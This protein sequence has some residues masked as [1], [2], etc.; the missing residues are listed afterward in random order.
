MND[1]ELDEIL[2]A[3]AERAR[4]LASR[5]LLKVYKKLGLGRIR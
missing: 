3:G 4:L 2:T 5:K 1:S